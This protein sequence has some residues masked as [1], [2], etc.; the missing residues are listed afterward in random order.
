MTFNLTWWGQSSFC[1]SKN[2]GAHKWQSWSVGVI[3]DS[4]SDSSSWLGCDWKNV[5]RNPQLDDKWPHYC[6][7]MRMPPKSCKSQDYE[8]I[9]SLTG[10]REGVFDLCYLIKHYHIGPILYVFFTLLTLKFIYIYIHFYL[11]IYY[12]YYHALGAPNIS[13]Y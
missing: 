5:D 13:F 2:K 9:G 7:L 8:A 6:L 3:A 10:G 12:Y 4:K 11:F 1:Y